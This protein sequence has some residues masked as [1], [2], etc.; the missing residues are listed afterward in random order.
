MARQYVAVEFKPGGHNY[1]FHHDGAPLNVGDDVTVPVGRPNQA[2]HTRKQKVK[3]LA[4]VDEKPAFSTKPVIID[5]DPDEAL[6][7]EPAVA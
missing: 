2:G 7:D 1:T 3:V 5:I 6:I 4:I